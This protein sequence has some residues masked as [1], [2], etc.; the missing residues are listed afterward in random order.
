MINWN[1]RHSM[2]LSII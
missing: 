1:I 2:L